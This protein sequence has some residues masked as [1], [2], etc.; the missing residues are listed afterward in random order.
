[1]QIELFST[2][3]MQKD[4]MTWRREP[5]LK[6]NHRKSAMTWHKGR[7]FILGNQGLNQSR[8]V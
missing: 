6:Y 3:S 8:F 5:N 4:E 2:D 7:L 1:M